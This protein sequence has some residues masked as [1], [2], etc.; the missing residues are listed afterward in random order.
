MCCITFC[1]KNF[2]LIIAQ[3]FFYFK[4]VLPSLSPIQLAASVAAA[5]DLVR[6]EQRRLPGVKISTSADFPMEGNLASSLAS[7]PDADDLMDVWR[8]LPNLK[9]LPETLLRR[10]SPEAIFQLNSAL[11]K[12]LKS[13]AKLSTNARLAQNARKLVDNPITVAAAV[14]N[15]RDLLHPARFLGGATCPNS[16]LWLAARRLLGDRG[17][18]ALGCYDMDSVGCGGCVTP[19]GWEALHN[20]SSQDL[21]I[22]M[23]Y[24][25]NV[26]SSGLAAKKV[27]LEDGEEAL[28]IGESLKEI[29]DMDGYRAALNTAREALHSV[30]PWNRSLCAIVGFMTNSN[31]L[32]EDLKGNPRRAAILSEFTDYVL[33]RNALNWENSQPFLSADELV[34]VWSQWRGKRAALFVSRT[35][36]KVKNKD[37][38]SNICRK[39]NQGDCPKQSDKECKSFFGTTLRHVCNKFV[40]NNKHCEKNHPRKDH[41]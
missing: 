5:S 12:D 6:Q 15:R 3:L 33:S 2:F 8:L 40:G 37:T 35:S 19:K 16:E 18:T 41:K 11:T 31:Y 4:G 23:F 36:E 1:N 29:A 22:K 10:L 32:Q 21:K 28:S 26:N 38:R 39:Y 24:L 14:D 27:A 17:L 7:R 34:Q 13:A 30:M 9:S 20:P 25:P